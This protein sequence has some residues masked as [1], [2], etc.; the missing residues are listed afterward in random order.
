MCAAWM[1]EETRHIKQRVFRE[2]YMELDK[3]QMPCT[4]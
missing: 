1:R 2:M 4:C 3:M